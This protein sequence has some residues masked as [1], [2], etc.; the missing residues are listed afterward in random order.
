MLRNR[1]V[2]RYTRVVRVV[3]WYVQLVV[4]GVLIFIFFVSWHWIQFHRTCITS[5]Q[6]N[7]FSSFAS[8]IHCRKQCSVIDHF[9]FLT[10]IT[11]CVYFFNVNTKTQT[12]WK[13]QIFSIE[14][15]WYEIFDYFKLCVSHIHM[16][17]CFNCYVCIQFEIIVVLIIILTAY[18]HKRLQYVTYISCLVLPLWRELEVLF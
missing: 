3:W 4:Q 11:P 14:D 17:H 10:V 5:I 15:A 2:L 18:F 16:I 8:D 1:I 13:E 6:H 7:Q 9:Q 12:F